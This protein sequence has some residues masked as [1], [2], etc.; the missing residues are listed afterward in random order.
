MEFTLRPEARW[1]D[2]V[3]I[4][5]ADVLFSWRTLRDHGRPNHRS[6]YGKV[7]HAER[8]VERTVRFTFQA[9]ADPEAPGDREMPLIMGLMPIL[10]EHAWKTREFDRTTLEPPLG[11]G[12]YRVARV[13]AGPFHRV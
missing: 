10:P 12:P 7:A 1:H 2:G 8:T 6:Y 5:P 4:T 11:S 3:P 13:R 9:S